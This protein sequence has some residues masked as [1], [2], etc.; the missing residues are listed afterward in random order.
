MSL[1]SLILVQLL[2]LLFILMLVEGYLEYTL[3]S[4]MGLYSSKFSIYFENNKS[5][6]SLT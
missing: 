1:E 2:G 4:A 3:V 5:N 6:T